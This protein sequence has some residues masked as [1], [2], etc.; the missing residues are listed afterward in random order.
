MPHIPRETLEKML[1]AARVEL[2]RLRAEN[3]ELRAGLDA[4][5]EA[6]AFF[7]LADMPAS[8]DI[9]PMRV[10]IPSLDLH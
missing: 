8:L 5:A 9:D 7:Q 1:E 2:D 10:F 3:A 6:E 4:E